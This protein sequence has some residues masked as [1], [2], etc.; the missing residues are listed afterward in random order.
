MPALFLPSRHPLITVPSVYRLPLSFA[1]AFVS[2]SFAVATVVDGCVCD[3]TFRF[4]FQGAYVAR[5]GNQFSSPKFPCPIRLGRLRLR[6]NGPPKENMVLLFSLFTTPY[7]HT[8]KLCFVVTRTQH[9]FTHMHTHSAG[10]HGGSPPYVNNCGTHH[11][12]PPEEFFTGKIKGKN[13]NK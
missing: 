2:N 5:K 9:T 11:T 8:H 13:T 12:T 10:E 7:T 6:E 3:R 1:C 4:L